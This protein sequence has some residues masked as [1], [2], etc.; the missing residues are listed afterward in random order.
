[1]ISI[2]TCLLVCL[3]LSAS[4]LSL[5]DFVPTKDMFRARCAWS[6]VDMIALRDQRE[7]KPLIHAPADYIMLTH[8][9]YFFS[10]E[11]L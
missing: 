8:S 1:M 4:L 11:F 2:R 7:R 5:I 10:L 6:A 9:G 3:L